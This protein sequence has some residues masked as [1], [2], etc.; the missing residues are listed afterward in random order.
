MFVIDF[1]LKKIEYKQ[2]ENKYKNVNCLLIKTI[3][4][5][6]DFISAYNNMM[7]YYNAEYGCNYCFIDNINSINSIKIIDERKVSLN[8]KV[9]R[10]RGYI[11][12]VG[13]DEM[14][15]SDLELIGIGKYNYLGGGKFAFSS[16][17]EK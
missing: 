2:I 8:T 17:D 12:Q 5:T 10:K 4:E 13:L 6:T 3:I 14:F 16:K 11:Y 7:H 1:L 9:I 15:S